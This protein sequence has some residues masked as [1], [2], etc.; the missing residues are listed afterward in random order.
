[1]ADSP[2]LPAIE[3][4]SCLVQADLKTV[5]LYQTDWEVVKLNDPLGGVV[6]RGSTTL[7]VEPSEQ[8]PSLVLAALFDYL[9]NKI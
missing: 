8:A 1:M 3:S 7:F 2:H 6:S 5:G 4:F 9:R